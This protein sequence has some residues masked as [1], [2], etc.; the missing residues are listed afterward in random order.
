M[1]S[2][3]LIGSV[4]YNVFT[5]FSSP[6][7][8]RSVDMQIKWGVSNFSPSADVLLSCAFVYGILTYKTEAPN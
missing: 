7:F 4:W 5:G 3:Y 6:I 2:E 1:C 8:C